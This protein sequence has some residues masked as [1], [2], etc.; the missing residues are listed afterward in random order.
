M[1]RDSIVI[2]PFLQT[3]NYFM[4][5][6]RLAAL[7][8]YS[9]APF[10]EREEMLP[11]QR[12]GRSRWGRKNILYLLWSSLFLT[13]LLNVITMLAVLPVASFANSWG[14]VLR[15]LSVDGSAFGGMFVVDS[16]ILNQFS[17]IQV[18][19]IQFLL[20]FAAFYVLGLM[21]YVIGLFTY[22]IVG[23]I[24]AIAVLFLPSVIGWVQFAGIYFSPF[25]WIEMTNWRMGYDLS[26]PNFLYMAAGF[27]LM[28]I[29][30]I[31][32]GQLRVTKAEWKNQ[33]E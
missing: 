5:I 7:C 8:F 10:M 1:I 4:K 23:Y 22:R 31:A 14:S 26:K 21:L 6:I 17:P 11:L 20:D 30:L 3:N 28:V 2:L 25:S 9:N 32:A 18:F 13:L 24:V 16:A 27:C 29:L 19:A 12:L 15:T 33:E